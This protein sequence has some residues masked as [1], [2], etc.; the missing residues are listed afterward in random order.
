MARVIEIM[1]VMFRILSASYIRIR[2][3]LTSN[4][5]NITDCRES[6]DTGSSLFSTSI[7][8]L[9][10]S[11]ANVWWCIFDEMADTPLGIF[12]QRDSQ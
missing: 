12:P 11:Y 5:N 4:T 8:S 10:W 6:S 2:S 1:G 7:G 9:C 3:D